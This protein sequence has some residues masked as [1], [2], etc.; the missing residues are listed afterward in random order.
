MTNQAVCSQIAEVRFS[1]AGKMILLNGKL[2][3]IMATI[4]LN[5][6]TCDAA[7]VSQG[8][9]T[10]TNTQACTYNVPVM[11]DLF[12]K[13]QQG[14]MTAATCAI[15]L[16]VFTSLGVISV[17]SQGKIWCGCAVVH[18]CR[19]CVF[20][21][22]Q[23]PHALEQVPTPKISQFC[24]CD[25]S[26]TFLCAMNLCNDTQSILHTPCCI[27]HRK[28]VQY[29]LVLM[30]RIRLRHI[31]STFPSPFT[32]RASIIIRFVVYWHQIYVQVI[33]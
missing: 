16:L 18:S 17:E 19:Y 1:L 20:L 32:L 3:F 22:T 14:T 33:Q 5:Y 23:Y 29:K 15:I 11:N 24:G 8:Q 21:L 9:E 31:P 4:P 30:W 28:T 10:L 13:F 26:C 7:C 27:V 6:R 12:V 2:I 25:S